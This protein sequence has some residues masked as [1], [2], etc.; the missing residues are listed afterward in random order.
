MTTGRKVL[1][2]GHRGYIGSVMAPELVR[3]GY[4]VVGLDTE[5]Y[6]GALVPDE[7]TIPGVRKDLRDVTAADLEGVWAVIHLA[8]LSNDPIGNLDDRWTE[9][10]NHLGTVRLAEIAKAAGVERFILSSSC[11]MYGLSTLEDVDETSPLAPQTAYARS[12]V[13]AEVA[14]R[15]LADDDFSPTLLRNGTVY[16][17]SPR[18]RLDTVLNDFAA[19]AHTRGRVVL[20]SDGKPWRPVIHVDDIAR[21]FAHVLAAPR[22]VIHNQAFNNGANHLNYTVLD[23]ARAAVAAVPGAAVQVGS[24]T[25][26]DQRTYRACFD[27]FAAAFPEFA[28]AWD[29]DRGA[30]ELADAYAR[31]GLTEADLSDPRWIRLRRLNTLL[32]AGQL[33]GDLRWAEAGVTA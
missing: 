13:S 33:D 15:R 5:Y 4:D 19:Q 23:I 26:E 16:G 29:I 24:G 25:P 28:F 9:E 30:K 17:I 11:I 22:E 2:T 8:A 10:I 27:K 7:L 6:D 20:Q 32:A 12:K 3:Q 21:S 1:L 18:M 31:V 14:L